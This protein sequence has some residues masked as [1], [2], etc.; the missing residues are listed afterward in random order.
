MTAHGPVR[1]AP[2]RLDDVAIGPFHD[3]NVRAFVNEGDMRTSLLGMEY[4][5]T[6]ARIEIAGGR[7]ILE[8]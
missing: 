2:V 8:R 4:L 5:N 3:N 6:F 7:L 1:T